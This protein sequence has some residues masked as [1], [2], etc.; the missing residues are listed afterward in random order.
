M[1]KFRRLTNFSRIKKKIRRPF[2]KIVQN[3]LTL[4][5]WVIKTHVALFHKNKLFENKIQCTILEYTG[6]IKRS[7]IQNLFNLFAN[8]KILF[9]KKFHTKINSAN[10]SRFLFLQSNF[11]NHDRLKFAGCGY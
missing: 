10:S 2:S 7:N 9:I 5:H 11:E 8:F 1:K 3:S 6:A 4:R